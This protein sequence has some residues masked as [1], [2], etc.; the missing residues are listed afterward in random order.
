LFPQLTTATVTAVRT[1]RQGYDSVSHLALVGTGGIAFSATNRID[2]VLLHGNA[3]DGSDLT[4]VTDPNQVILRDGL[5]LNTSTGVFKAITS[6]A[7]D[8]RKAYRIGYVATALAR[9]GQSLWVPM[10][11][12][13]LCHRWRL[14]GTR[15]L[16]QPRAF[17]L[18]KTL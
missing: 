3:S 4:P 15:L 7:S 14:R 13:R 1:D 2:L 18:A 17:F 10:P 9:C 8:E 11:P 16:L 12:A 6:N 5:I